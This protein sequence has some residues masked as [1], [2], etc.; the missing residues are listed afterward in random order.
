MIELDLDRERIY[1]VLRETYEICRERL[2]T[3]FDISVDDFVKSINLF[4]DSNRVSYTVPLR[5]PGKKYPG[6]AIEV[7][8]R[9]AKVFARIPSRS[10]NH[11]KQVFLN[12]YLTVL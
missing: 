10:R 2:E 11:P 5:L 8:L 1:T 3:D 9:R 6:L 4:L 7:N 12:R